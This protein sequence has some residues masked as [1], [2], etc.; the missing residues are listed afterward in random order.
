[1]DISLKAAECKG[2]SS[3]RPEWY[4][5]TRNLQNHSSVILV[6]SYKW[7]KN[8]QTISLTEERTNRVFGIPHQCFREISAQYR[9]RAPPGE[10][11]RVKVNMRC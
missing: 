7:R 5:E 4:W 3:D 9:A 10:I 11:Q 1:V 8:K 6:P 2:L